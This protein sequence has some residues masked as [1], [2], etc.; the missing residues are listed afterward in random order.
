MLLYHDVTITPFT[1]DPNLFIYTCLHRYYA[2]PFTFSIFYSSQHFPYVANEP[3][4]CGTAS[5][6]PTDSMGQSQHSH[7]SFT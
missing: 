5:M 2:T 4:T 3:V 6:S 1:D 7:G